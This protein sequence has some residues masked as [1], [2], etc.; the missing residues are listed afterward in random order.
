MGIEDLMPPR[1]LREM[2]RERVAEELRRRG[3][4]TRGDLVRLTGLS[5]STVAA[6]VADLQ[7]KGLVI[8]G[9]DGRSPQGRGR[10]A[11][12]LALNP[13]GAALLGVD[14]DHRYVRVVVADFLLTVLAEREAAVDV[15]THA[16]E[17]LDLAAELVSEAL[18]EAGVDRCRIVGVGMGLP[19]PID[20]RTGTV[21]PSVVLPSW[22]GL[23]AGR[24]LGQRIGIDV[25]VDN[26]AN[27]GALAES[28]FGAA[29]GVDNV[30]YVKVSSGIGA[31]IVIN[32]SIHHGVTGIAG[33][34]GHVHVK[35]DGAVCRCG[36]RGCLETVAS[37][38][39]LTALLAPTHGPDLR[40]DDVLKLLHDGDLGTRRV[41]AEAGHAIGRVLA[42]LCNLL[43]PGAVVIGG[44]LS[45]AGEVLLNSIRE[46]IDRY[47]LAG[48]AAAVDVRAGALGSRAEVLGALA[49]V[50]SGSEPVR[51]ALAAVGLS[52]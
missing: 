13:A 12:M 22:T 17:A 31:G 45:A 4:A 30:V 14:C 25:R 15:D 21:G 47:A 39:A 8:E 6:V 38:G 11:A 2:N 44:E 23:E 34:I 51:S 5:R 37:T 7:S 46:S 40:V 24:E 1:S 28:V 16:F 20:A 52:A 10:P 19:G 3:Q 33:E 48:A 35:D 29:R 9:D 27:L 18:Q 26:D 43:N 32:G 42:D 36:N 50:N 49:L 41:I